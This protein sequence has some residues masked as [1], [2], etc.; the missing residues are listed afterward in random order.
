MSIRIVG[1]QFKNKRLNSPPKTTRPSSNKLR[2]S[3]FNICQNH[4]NETFFLDLFAGS[5]AIGLEAISRG[6][7]FVC[8]IEK[9]KQAISCIR[10]NIKL[11]E[12]KDKTKVIQGNVLDALK[13]MN[14]DYQY[15]IIFIDPPYILYEKHPDFIE[16][17]INIILENDI[18][19]EKGLIF[20]EKPFLQKEQIPI[21]KKLKLLS[22][23]KIS[24]TSLYEYQKI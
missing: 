4:I 23:R 14:S 22:N 5:G 21:F 2:E 10:E 17:I 24:S 19:K 7:S 13:K 11:L 8:F 9:N 20:F 18:I 15:D 1:G 6:A 16:E 3:L 12:V